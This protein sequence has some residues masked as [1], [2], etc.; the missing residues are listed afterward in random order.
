MIYKN[1]LFILSI[2]S[3]YATPKLTVVIVVDQLAY[4]YIPKLDPYLQY[5]LHFLLKH[6]V[7]YTNAHHAHGTTST[8]VGHA[9]IGTGTLPKNHG[10][11]ANSWYTPLMEKQDI[12]TKTVDLILL[13]GITHAF[14]AQ[15]PTNRALA[16]SLKD[17]APLG[18][19][20]TAAP[21]IWLDR[22]SDTFVTNKSDPIITSVLERTNT[23]LQTPHRTHWQLTYTDSKYYQFQHIDNY[24]YASEP[25]LFDQQMHNETD[26]SHHKYIHMMS[27]LPEANQ[28]LLDMATDYITKTYPTLNN[29]SLLVWISLS[30]LDKIG[31]IYGPFSREVIDMIYHLDKQL[32]LFFDHLAHLVQ[33]RDTLYVLTADHGVMPIPE[34]IRDQYPQARRIMMSE[35]VDAVNKQIKRKYKIANVIQKHKTPNLYLDWQKIHKLPPHKQ[36]PLIN[37]IVQLLQESPGISRAYEA[38][39]LAQLPTT[40]GSIVWLMQNNIYT[41]RSGDIIVQIA[42]YTIVSKYTGGTKHDQPYAYNTHVPLILYQAEN[43]GN[44]TITQQVWIQQLARTLSNLLGLKPASPHMLS[45]L[46]GIQTMSGLE[47]QRAQNHLAPIFKT[48]KIR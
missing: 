5:G 35:L 43:V 2:T 46:P 14:L 12:N 19:V 21:I 20:G 18:L 1:I 31:H 16:L 24:Q 6:G 9:G 40:T 38:A 37:D 29:G 41:G 39:Q 22:K 32:A 47:R 11:I 4:H 26:T 8:A 44:K 33:P 25:S 42:P 3:L 7:V 48:H 27:R 28:I 13:P 45:A 10:V 34:L 17:Y 15:Q 23:L 36:Q 30:S